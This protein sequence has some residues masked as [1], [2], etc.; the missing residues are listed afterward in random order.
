[1][2]S[3]KTIL[4]SVAFIIGSNA[5]SQAQNNYTWQGINQLKG[6]SLDMVK[7]LACSK[8]KKVYVTGA[9]MNNMY[10]GAQ[11]IHSAGINDI[12]LACYTN[13]GSLL[14]LQRGGGK[15]DD[16]ATCMTMMSNDDLILGGYI[17]DS[18]TLGNLTSNGTGRRFFIAKRTDAG[19]FSWITTLVPG[20]EYNNT[21]NLV[22]SDVR[23]NIYAAGIYSGTLSAGNK[24]ITSKGGRDIYII[25]LDPEGT[26]TDLFS[27]GGS[28]NDEITALSVSASGTICIAGSTLAD[29]YVDGYLITADVQSGNSSDPFILCMNPNFTARWKIQLDGQEYCSISSLSQD[30]HD[31]TYAAGSYKSQMTVGEQTFH[32]AG[33]TDGFLFKVN[34]TGGFAWAKAFGSSYYDYANDVKS[35]QH[36]TTFLTGNLSDTIMIDS[37]TL[38]PYE[39]VINSAFLAAFSP[40]GKALW[41]DCISGTG[42]IEGHKANYD[43]FG[44]IY[45]SGIFNYGNLETQTDTLISLGDQ[46]LFLAYYHKCVHDQDEITGRNSLCPGLA[47]DLSIDPY[48]D[49]IIWNDEVTDQHVF[50]VD[51]PGLFRAEMRDPFGCQQT[52]SAYVTIA[53][54]TYFSLGDDTLLPIGDSLLLTAPENFSNFVWQDGSDNASFLAKATENVP[55]IY[56]FWLTADDP[57]GCISQDTILIE[58]YSVTGIN[59]RQQ[60]VMKVFPVPATEFLN[61]TVDKTI[62]GHP[63]IVDLV[64]PDGKMILH[65]P[66]EDYMNGTVIRI[67]VGSVAPGLYYVRL[68]F[69]NESISSPCVVT[70]RL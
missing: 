1:M 24:S 46:D 6:E 10:G 61:L 16:M 57:N 62:S 2:T 29:F 21:L 4:I 64:N 53:E 23:G 12:F 36:G 15:K 22:G 66:V 63:L 58:F 51:Q 5:L 55:G 28:N 47:T 56:T 54:V 34:S 9:F 35:D 50:T 45:V 70:P 8:G 3:F 69:G 42:R 32:A 40:E 17:T 33:Y 14:T 67:N 31:N 44:N 39:D 38:T 27:I 11:S 68:T 26:I 13:T 48:Y 41:G 49:N 65:Q 43:L 37:V 19:Q 52:D 25:K 18:I 7:G 59:E 20:S 60:A 30:I